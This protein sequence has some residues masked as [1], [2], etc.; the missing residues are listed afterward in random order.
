MTLSESVFYGMT[1]LGGDYGR[2]TVYSIPVTGGSP[3]PL[4]SF[5]GSNG[6]NPFDG[7]LLLIGS[8]LYGMTSAGGAYNDGTIFMINTDGSGYKDLLDF[9]LNFRRF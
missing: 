9:N 1:T 4:L 2:G 5:S 6:L 7:S 3:T 8:A